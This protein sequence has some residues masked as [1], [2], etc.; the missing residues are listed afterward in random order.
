MR[1]LPTGYRSQLL[2]T[3]TEQVPRDVAARFRKVCAAT[4]AVD[5][6]FVCNQRVTIS[7]QRQEERLALAVH[8]AAGRRSRDE[9]MQV[10]RAFAEAIPQQGL[11]FLEDIA[12]PAWREFGV[13]LY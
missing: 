5:K 9:H 12:V 3:E 6:G 4:P 13:Q 11:A 7:D 8:L 2:A 1:P 10:M